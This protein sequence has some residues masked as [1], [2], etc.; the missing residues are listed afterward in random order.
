MVKELSSIDQASQAKSM[1][2]CTGNLED[3]EEGEYING[4][5]GEPENGEGPVRLPD[6]EGSGNA[7][8]DWLEN[9]QLHGGNN[10]MHGNLDFGEDMAAVNDTSGGVSRS[11]HNDVGRDPLIKS[12]VRNPT[13]GAFVMNDLGHIKSARKRPRNTRSPSPLSPEENTNGARSFDL[14]SPLET[15]RNTNEDVMTDAT[16]EGG[17]PTPIG[18]QM[19][20]GVAMVN[21]VDREI[22]EETD[23][24]MSVG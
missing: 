18:T 8:S 24:T 19:H 12:P 20:V 6:N 3:V 7:Q 2:S 15:S 5:V 1:D 13:N 21:A 9:E 14:N 17:N 10:H 11:Q 4:E 16:R 23:A 22:A